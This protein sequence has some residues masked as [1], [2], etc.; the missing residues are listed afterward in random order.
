MHYKTLFALVATLVLLGVGCG[1]D[2][3][4]PRERELTIADGYTMQHLENY[5]LVVGDDKHTI[6]DGEC[7]VYLDGENPLSVASWIPEPN[8]KKLGELSY[9]FTTFRENGNTVRVDAKAL[10]APITFSLDNPTGF[11]RC[12]DEFET[13]LGTVVHTP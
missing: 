10:S 2:E 8:T 7:L 13:M 1:S 3:L 12:I 11:Q 9:N 6:S 4:P 5:Q